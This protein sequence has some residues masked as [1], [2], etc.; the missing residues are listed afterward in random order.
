MPCS[1][2]RIRA[3][4]IPSQVEAILIRTRDLSTPTD[5]YSC[6]SY[7]HRSIFLSRIEDFW[8]ISR[9]IAYLNDVQSLVDGTLGI[10]RETSIN[11][12]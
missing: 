7:Q 9:K 12:S 8:M 2:W 6:R 3:A 11:L 5:L 4:W 1:F 10:E